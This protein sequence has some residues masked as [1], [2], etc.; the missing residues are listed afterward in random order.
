MPL[1]TLVALPGEPG[2]HGVG[3]TYECSVGVDWPWARALQPV[4]SRVRLERWARSGCCRGHVVS[5]GGAGRT[6]YGTTP[7]RAQDAVQAGDRNCGS[8]W[9]PST[10]S[11]DGPATH[12]ATD[13]VQ[14]D[15]L[16]AQYLLEQAR[17]RSRAGDHRR[18]HRHRADPRHSLESRSA[19]FVESGKRADQGH[20]GPPAEETSLLRAQALL[21]VDRARRRR[22]SCSTAARH[23]RDRLDER[24]HYWMLRALSA[25]RRSTT[26]SPATTGSASSARRLGTDPL[27]QIQSLQRR[28]PCRRT[29]APSWLEGTFHRGLLERWSRH[30]HPPGAACPDVPTR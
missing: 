18:V 8:N 3:C 29:G 4:T 10:S 22:S 30:S 1:P 23:E 21:G 9:D 25:E 17:Q 2:A 5:L 11:R 20:H 28:A 13:L 24:V 16:D 19:G 15:W 6:K 12:C 7:N 26:P 14:V 27:P